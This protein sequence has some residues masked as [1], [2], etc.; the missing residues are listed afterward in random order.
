MLAR[1]SQS[2][3]GGTGTQGGGSGELR[4]EDADYQ[5][6]QNHSSIVRMSDASSPENKQSE[7]VLD[8]LETYWREQ[9]DHCQNGASPLKDILLGGGA[10]GF[11]KSR[12]ARTAGQGIK[13]NQLYK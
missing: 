4:S 1:L 12:S 11:D 8:Q 5:S 9:G 7:C 6:S 10:K 3:F 13:A 2:L